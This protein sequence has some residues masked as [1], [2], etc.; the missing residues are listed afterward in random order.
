MSR[1]LWDNK[2]NIKD[3]EHVLDA[4]GRIVASYVARNEMQ[5]SEV[6]GIIQHVFSTLCNLYHTPNVRSIPQ[7][8][9]DIEKSITADYLV[10]LEDGKRLKMLKRHLR[11]SYGLTPEQ[12]RERW[13]LS[14]DYPMVAPNY[15]KKRSALAK[16]NGLGQARSRSYRQNINTTAVAQEAELPESSS[17]VVGF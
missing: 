16:N 3:R 5:P 17:A 7:A 8:P 10:C 12:Y 13:S 11:T 2:D 15:A 6:S 9:V 14:M 4:L 1:S